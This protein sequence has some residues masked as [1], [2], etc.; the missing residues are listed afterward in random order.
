[1]LVDSS[2]ESESIGTAKAAEMIAY[3]R[4][5]LRAFGT[6]PDGPTLIGTDNMSNLRVAST[7]S[8]PTRSK[9]F[10]RRYE[11][12]MQRV[13]EGQVVL[14]HVP[15]INMPADFLTK[16]IPITK[17]DQSVVYATGAHN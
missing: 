2:M 15:D 11:V 6:P 8:C 3:A 17:L 14:K 9:H 4:E 12:L 10:L 1:M 7:S 5:I 13:R 16:W